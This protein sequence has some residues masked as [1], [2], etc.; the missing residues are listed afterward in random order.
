MKGHFNSNKQLSCFSKELIKET[1]LYFSKR[2][3]REISDEEANQYLNS[4]A[5][6][7]LSLIDAREP[8]ISEGQ[9]SCPP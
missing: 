8:D 2:F 7:A 1:Q 5:N 6:L 9:I 4:L 3:K